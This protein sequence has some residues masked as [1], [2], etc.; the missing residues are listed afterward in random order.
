MCLLLKLLMFRSLSLF[1][2][3][4][5]FSC[6][7]LSVMP[8]VFI[9][10]GH[11]GGVVCLLAPPVPSAAARCLLVANRNRSVQVL[12]GGI[13]QLTPLMCYYFN[14]T[15]LRCQISENIKNSNILSDTDLMIFCKFNSN[16]KKTL[17][18][19]KSN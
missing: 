10:G 18:I 14:P 4:F 16:K 5:T 11:D 15:L 3:T 1:I 19:P 9:L 8:V 17:L 2:A 13:A 6:L 7:R 12:C